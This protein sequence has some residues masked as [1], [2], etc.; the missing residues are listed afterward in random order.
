MTKR[1]DANRDLEDRLRTRLTAEVDSIDDATARRLRLAR[2][3]ALEHI[4]PPGRRAAVWLPAGAV[5]ATVALLAVAMLARQ[6]GDP[7]PG[8]PGELSAQADDLE[9]MVAGEDLELIEELEFFE[10][11]EPAGD[12]G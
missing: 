1:D 5:A 9:L 7:I 11:L 10:W 2:H 6:S 4:D 3:A 12:S 8:V